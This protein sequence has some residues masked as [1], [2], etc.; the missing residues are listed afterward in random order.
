MDYAATLLS[1][2]VRRVAFFQLLLVLLVATASLL[3]QGWVSAMSACYG[4]LISILCVFLL[5]WR[6]NRAGGFASQGSKLGIFWLLLGIA[7]RFGVAL[8]GFGFGIGILQLPAVPQ[9]AAFAVSQFAFF[10]AAK[11]ASAGMQ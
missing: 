8:A 3:V 11:P 7:E 10:A 9:V 2:T 1:K 5:A 4:G 6:V